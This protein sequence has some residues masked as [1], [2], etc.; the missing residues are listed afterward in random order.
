MS[1]TPFWAPVKSGTE[2][3][4]RGLSTSLKTNRETKMPIPADRHQFFHN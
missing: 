2:V 4:A 3:D 1:V